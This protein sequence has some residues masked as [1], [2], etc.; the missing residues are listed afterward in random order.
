MA[1]YII[2]LTEE[3]KHLILRLANERLAA[4]RGYYS[5]DEENLNDIKENLVKSTPSLFGWQEPDTRQ[6]IA[7]CL[8]EVAGI[9]E[10]G[11]VPAARRLWEADGIDSDYEDDITLAAEGLD[12]L[13][14]FFTD[15]EETDNED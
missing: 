1:N 12:E 10:N 5:R 3:Q 15:Y 14:S 13:A 6:N 11:I 8:S 9:L 4:I 7:N 2:E